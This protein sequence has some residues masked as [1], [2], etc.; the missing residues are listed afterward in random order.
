MQSFLAALLHSAENAHFYRVHLD[1]GKRTAHLLMDEQ[2][3]Q[4]VSA[5][6]EGEPTT[7]MRLS[8]Q[9][10]EMEPSSEGS[11]FERAPGGISREEFSRVAVH[12]RAQYLRTGSPPDKVAKHYA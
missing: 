2:A 3:Q 9:T 1:G 8:L 11:D 6:P 10:G 7:E 5:T 4:V 12:L